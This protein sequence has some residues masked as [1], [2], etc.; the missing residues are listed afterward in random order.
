MNSVG[1]TAKPACRRG[2]RPASRGDWGE[3]GAL[4]SFIFGESSL[5]GMNYSTFFCQISHASR[6]SLGARETRVRRGARGAETRVAAAHSQPHEE[7]LITITLPE[8]RVRARFPPKMG[9]I[10]PPMVRAAQASP[11]QPDSQ[12]YCGP[13]P[14]L[15]TL[16]CES[17]LAGISLPGARS[18]RVLA[19]PACQLAPPLGPRATRSA[20]MARA[21]RAR[22]LQRA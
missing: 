15:E 13:G 7:Q 19:A 11:E 22:R 20:P 2:R 6:I 21:L 18:Q 1:S 9:L 16:F 3:E 10:H 14:G 4:F 17:W 8:K 12:K 5:L